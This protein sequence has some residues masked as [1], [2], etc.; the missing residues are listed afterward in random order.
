MLFALCGR[1]AA[2][3]GVA[4]EAIMVCHAVSHNDAFLASH[5][6]NQQ[7]H[8]QQHCSTIAETPDTSKSDNS[9]Q[10]APDTLSSQPTSF[11]QQHGLQKRVTRLSAPILPTH[12]VL[13]TLIDWEGKPPTSHELFTKLHQDYPDVIHSRAVVSRQ[14]STN[15][16]DSA[17][18]L[19]EYCTGR[20][21]TAGGLRACGVVWCLALH[22][23][24]EAIYCCTC[25]S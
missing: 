5:N 4:S 25:C 12:V 20:T 11:Q 21:F 9:S 22:F 24:Q 2:A 1:I 17:A 7:H 16:H 6:R 10:V 18:F 14:P 23:M 19:V 3:H 13:K 15:K 8:Q